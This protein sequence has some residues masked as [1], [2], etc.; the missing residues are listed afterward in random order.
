MS[1]QESERMEDSKMVAELRN[2]LGSHSKLLVDGTLRAICATGIA[3]GVLLRVQ[4]DKRGSMPF[5]ARLNRLEMDLDRV[6]RLFPQIVNKLH[7][8]EVHDY[9]DALAY[10]GSQEISGLDLMRKDLSKDVI[11]LVFAVGMAEGHLVAH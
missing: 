11:S 8:Y 2:F 1:Q 6:N 10:L 3:A 5:W 7:E 9:D 4:Q